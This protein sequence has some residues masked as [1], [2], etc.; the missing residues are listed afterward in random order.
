MSSCHDLLLA[1]D[2]ESAFPLVEKALYD[3][4]LSQSGK[5][6]LDMA[7]WAQ[8]ETRISSGVR[9]RDLVAPIGDNEPVGR[10]SPATKDSDEG[11]GILGPRD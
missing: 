9:G 5:K 1:S 11:S 2:T 3:V 6:D 10:K 8:V 7:F 4:A